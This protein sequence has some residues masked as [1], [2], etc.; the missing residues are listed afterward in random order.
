MI[1]FLVSGLWHGSAWNYVAWGALHG[2]AYCLNKLFNKQW[3]KVPSILRW[4]MTFVF[5]NISW[6]FFRAS[7][8]NQ[9]L[10]LLGRIVRM[11]SFSIS[12]GLISS[13]SLS[14]LSFIGG[15]IEAFA[16]FIESYSIVQLWGF[17]GF[18]FVVAL[19]AKDRIAK[20]F[21]PTLMKCISTILML[22]WSVVS[23]STVTE[24]I[25]GSF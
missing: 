3:E 6:V 25:Y 5:I 21:K 16:T 7:T 9:A 22:S 20:N 11:D 17:M 15:R 10:E 23:L 14:E 2:I 8:V 19:C 24:F 12:E 4:V 1:I 18:S 13:F